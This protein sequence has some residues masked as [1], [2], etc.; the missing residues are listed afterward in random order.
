MNPWIAAGW[1]TFGAI[2]LLT[3]CLAWLRMLNLLT[4]RIAQGIP[5]WLAALAVIPL[6]LPGMAGLFLGLGNLGD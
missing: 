4:G 6:T 1:F 5:R 2:C 3:G